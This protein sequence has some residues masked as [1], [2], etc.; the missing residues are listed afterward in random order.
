M[1]DYGEVSLAALPCRLLQLVQHVG[2]ISSDGISTCTEPVRLG[3]FFPS[4]KKA[5]SH[6]GWE[7][8]M[9]LSIYR[10]DP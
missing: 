7:V 10:I 8:L 6:L 9:R 3:A 4:V 5:P 2:T 1:I